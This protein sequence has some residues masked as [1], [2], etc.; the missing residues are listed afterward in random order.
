MSAPRNLF[1][2]DSPLANLAPGAQAAAA[3]SLL[4]SHLADLRK[5]PLNLNLAATIDELQA[6]LSKL[7]DMQVLFEAGQIAAAGV[8]V[9]LARTRMGNC[10]KMARAIAK[11]LADTESI[12]L[13]T[14]HPHKSNAAPL[15]DQKA[16]RRAYL[17]EAGR[18]D[19]AREE[20]LL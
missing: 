3:A 5:L 18:E 4:S 20:G 6:Q 17:L 16:R 8:N 11:C 7:D 1:Q 13:A 2:A 15:D 14:V 19:Q 12:E 9:E 10:L